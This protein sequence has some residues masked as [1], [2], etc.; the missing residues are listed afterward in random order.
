[1]LHACAAG[2]VNL[3]A[4]CEPFGAILGGA[5]TCGCGWFPLAGEAVRVLEP[6]P[7]PRSREGLR[8]PR[9]VFSS[10]DVIFNR[11]CVDAGLNVDALDLY[12]LMHNVKMLMVGSADP[13]RLLG[14]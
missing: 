8:P 6:L 2:F 3:F 7:Y 11:S 4:M 12:C 13:Y 5:G 10:R 1:M 14:I 9:T